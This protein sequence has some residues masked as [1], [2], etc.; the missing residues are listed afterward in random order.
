MIRRGVP[1]G[2]T[3]VLWHP[4]G[5]YLLP[6]SLSAPLSARVSREAAPAPKNISTERRTT[7]PKAEVQS[8]PDKSFISARV[9]LT[10][11]KTALGRPQKDGLL[12]KLLLIRNRVSFLLLKKIALTLNYE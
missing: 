9:G 10:D 1:D 6:S 11:Q 3:R 5:R 4:R 7:N 2:I 8:I 12:Q